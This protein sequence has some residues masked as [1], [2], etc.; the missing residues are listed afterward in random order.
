MGYA[1]EVA[2]LAMSFR[3]V[4]APVNW[5]PGNISSTAVP[6]PLSL[7]SDGDIEDRIVN[8]YGPRDIRDEGRYFGLGARFR[9]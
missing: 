7:M 8:Q 9:F 6:D 1:S 4:A 5:Y 3:G 2:C